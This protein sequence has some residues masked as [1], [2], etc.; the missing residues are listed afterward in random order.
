MI[1]QYVIFSIKRKCNK[2]YARCVFVRMGGLMPCQIVIDSLR[3]IHGKSILVDCGRGTQVADK[4]KGWSF[5]P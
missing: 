1:S 3:Q 5:K 4:E 2:K